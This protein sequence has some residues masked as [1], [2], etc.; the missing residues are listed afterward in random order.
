MKR[1]PRVV[2][3]KSNELSLV[4][5]STGRVLRKVRVQSALIAE[6]FQRQQSGYQVGLR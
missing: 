6:Q 5:A 4:R 3:Q 2:I 1:S